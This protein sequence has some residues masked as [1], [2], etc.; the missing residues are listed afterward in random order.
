MVRPICHR[1]LMSNVL[2][3]LIRKYR[4][5]VRTYLGSAD[6][7]SPVYGAMMIIVDSGIIYTLYFV[8]IV[9]FFSL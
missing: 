5:L 6:T 1:R 2:A 7:G 9:I 3:L 4:R 8:R